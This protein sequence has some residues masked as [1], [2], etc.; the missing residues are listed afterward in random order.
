[1]GSLQ[2]A[3][4][5]LKKYMFTMKILDQEVGWRLSFFLEIAVNL[6]CLHS[7]QLA[8][9]FVLFVQHLT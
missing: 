8:Y 3:K 9:H 2:E 5:K 6:L 4:C 1:M 7:D